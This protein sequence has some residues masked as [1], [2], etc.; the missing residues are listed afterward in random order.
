MDKHISCYWSF[1]IFD[2]Q[3][4]VGALVLSGLVDSRV[5]DPQCCAEESWSAAVTGGE[6]SA[7]GRSRPPQV[8]PTSAGSRDSE[9]F[10]NGSVY[11][12]NPGRYS[13][14]YLH[15]SSRLSDLFIL[16]TP[17]WFSVGGS[18]IKRSSMAAGNNKQVNQSKHNQHWWY[19]PARPEQIIAAE[20]GQ[21]LWFV[22]I[23][24]NSQTRNWKYN[25][26]RKKKSFVTGCLAT[27]GLFFSLLQ[28]MAVLCQNRKQGKM[29][30]VRLNSPAQ[31]GL[32][33][34][35]VSEDTRCPPPPCE[36]LKHIMYC[37]EK[38][39]TQKKTIRLTQ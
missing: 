4:S 38:K 25:T 16:W 5:G 12:L 14:T 22:L 37:M 27:W 23:R 21:M 35:P 39:K 8:L 31:C 18:G 30:L 17:Y 19:Q 32:G 26:A 3:V 10:M 34:V 29:G 28:K 20:M 13:Y 9:C 7:C 33:G 2:F 15:V 6:A 24:S 1:A 36:A 11:G